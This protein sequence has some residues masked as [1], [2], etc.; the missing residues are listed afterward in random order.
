[1]PSNTEELQKVVVFLALDYERYPMEFLSKLPNVNC[2]PIA[3]RDDDNVDV[4]YLKEKGIAT[5]H[6]TDL[7]TEAV[8][9]FVITLLF[10]SAKYLPDGK[11]PCM[12]VMIYLFP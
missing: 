12:R 11:V 10:A 6:L 8:S 4:K 5:G 2:V 7:M 1:M 9:E 3:S